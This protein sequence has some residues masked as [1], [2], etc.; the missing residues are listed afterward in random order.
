MKRHLVILTGILAILLGV[1]ILL[2]F[3]ETIRIQKTQ[4]RP[5]LAGSFDFDALYD[6][7]D[8]A[9]VRR[10]YEAIRGHA[11]RLSGSEGDLE[12]AGVAEQHFRSL[13]MEVIVQR[14]P[15]TVPVTR[16][17]ELLEEGTEEEG[18]VQDVTITPFWPNVIRTCTTPATGI[19]G[20][21][22]DAGTG[23]LPDL[24]GKP[25]AGRIALVEMTPA[26]EWLDVAKLG[27]AAILFKASADAED[28]RKKLLHFP[29]NIPRFLVEGD[30]VDE[31]VGRTVRLNARVDWAV[32]EA[33]SVFGILRPEIE[34]NEALFLIADSDSWSVVPD[35]APGD[36]EAC[37]LAGLLEVATSLSEQRSALARTIV[38]T[39][40]SGRCLGSEGVRRF[41]DVLGN[42]EL[43]EMNYKLL[44]RRLD[45]A[46][47]QKT[48]SEGALEA[49]RESSF[50]ALDAQGA[51]R[52]WNTHGESAKDAFS[53][54]LQGLIDRHVI[55]MQDAQSDAKLAW[56][57]AGRPDAGSLFDAQ[58]KASNRLRRARAAAGADTISLKQVFTD[59]LDAGRCREE[60]E[61]ELQKRAGYAK[62]AFDWQNDSVR[63]ADALASYSRSYYFWFRPTPNGRALS[64]AGDKTLSLELERARDAIVRTWLTWQ[65]SPAADPSTF[66][67]HIANRIR[68][69]IGSIQFGVGET[70]DQGTL[71]FAIAAHA[72]FRFRGRGAARNYQTPLREAIAFDDV[73]AQSQLMAGMAAQ[74]AS[75]YEPMGLA[76]QD[77]APIY[78]W[79]SDYGGEVVSSSGSRSILANRR[80][81]DA[82]VVLKGTGSG[83]TEGRDFF[84][85]RSRDGFFRI[86][87]CLA[88]RASNALFCDAYTI[89]DRTGEIT[90]ARDLGA[91][92]QKYPTYL[93]KDQI[94]REP[95]NRVTIL[96]SQFAPTDIY[97][98]TG[99]EGRRLRPELLDAN[100]RSIPA[101]FA[102]WTYGDEGGTLFVPPGQRFY[103]VLKEEP[104]TRGQPS[105]TRGFL[106]GY[107]PEETPGPGK[108]GFWGP[109]YL[110]G[111]DHRIRFQDFDAAVSVAAA[112]RERLDA[113]VRQGLG[114]AAVLE[115]AGKAD[116]FLDRAADA[117]GAY[118]YTAAYRDLNTSLAISN[119]A[120]PLVRKAVADALAGLLLYLFL[121]VPF[122]LFAE[123]LL[124]GSNDIR[125][126]IAGTFAI[127]IFLFFLIQTLHPVYELI[128]S[129]MIVLVGFVI[130]MLCVLILA[131]LSGKFAER[132][133]ELRL[134]GGGA[135]EA[136]SDVSRAS[137]AGTAFSLGVNSM[138]KR[139]VRTAYTVATL[140]LISFSMVCFTAPHPE[141]VTRKVVAGQADFNGILLRRP[142]NFSPLRIQ[143]GDKAQIIM[144]TGSSWQKSVPPKG[145]GISYT[146][147]E[148]AIR[149][150]TVHT[151]MHLDA[152]EPKLTGV[153]ETLLP[154]GRWFESNE[155]ESM[156]ISEQMASTLGIDPGELND[157]DIFVQ[158]GGFD[159]KLI[160]VFSSSAM[161]QLEDV[162]GEPLLPPAWSPVKAGGRQRSME[163]TQRLAGPAGGKVSSLYR[164]P[165]ADTAILPFHPTRVSIGDD[166]ATSAVIAF[167]ELPYGEMSEMIDTLMDR[168][169]VFFT[170][171]LDGVSFFG[172]KLRSVGMDKLIDLGVPLLIASF[173]VFTTMLGSVYERQ[174][175]ISVYSAVGLSPR[176]VF[177]LFLAESLVYGVI[178]VVGGYMLGLTLQGVSHRFG[179]FLGL[180][181]DYSSRS[182][183]YVCLTIM[184][185]VIASTFLP[186]R[187]A[188][189]IASPSE[190]VSWRMP[191]EVKEGQLDFQ[192]PF[193]Y[194][195][196]DILAMVP[197]LTGWFDERGED[198]SG[199]FSA[200]PPAVDIL[201]PNDLPVF[202]VESTAWLRPYD[203]GVSQRVRI[204]LRPSEDPR[205]YIVGIAIHQLTGDLNSWR[206]T[207]TR[208]VKILRRHLLSWRA[209]SQRGKDRLYEQGRGMLGVGNE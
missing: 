133:R 106:L 44:T 31:L 124:V 137:A 184:A 76:G 147:A 181:I 113:Q 182:A 54:A 88:G 51:A 139:P 79:F 77:R 191:V 89:D 70:V 172:G 99:T 162:D 176:H 175:E 154:G 23:V 58:L 189:K 68:V 86:P 11:T 180:A 36:F 146:P 109:G 204:E 187:R 104:L 103:A 55:V 97:R 53:D 16:V 37:S 115:F 127:F 80:V 12:A 6:S 171:A 203:L 21:V 94:Y 117:I 108:D 118:E 71:P 130:F 42:R 126:R 209:L 81:A 19:V 199:E 4:P 195:G 2:R 61:E 32:R 48:A 179:D 46:A 45:E 98:L 64:F 60:L 3:Q 151:L 18:P 52:L 96:L 140:V 152:E 73:A 85:Q 47:E 15:V 159:R 100:F 69:R 173:I 200:S 129:G 65:G 20:E 25:I 208:F 87:A 43:F 185:A 119:R 59:V 205:I 141:L 111:R 5:E 132:I 165:G 13:G 72:E 188:A 169:P 170:F 116:R 183:I 62:E 120:Y 84:V 123:R 202:A 112:N 198:S 67:D 193:T 122:S 142:G 107:E 190:R 38:F 134:R 105:F 128:T 24:D 136:D 148:G 40:L 155:E 30:G 177:Y 150:T 167:D 28:Y 138:R 125:A 186:A 33:R 90:G 63:L 66:S 49:Y 157:R 41:L 50:W 26:M 39:T 9:G 163:K 75:G 161:D 83:G 164:A 206:R 22:V 194:L 8:G 110:A 160:G 158:F 56:V 91:A 178:G 29:A 197:F 74:V 7:I 196:R 35:L 156:I 57:E 114:D 201:W 17:C 93:G 149:A 14:F 34:S 143:F 92:G 27:A 166:D 131:F 82:M 135:A 207:N 153:D 101:E 121:L 95:E 78:S 174:K 144:R 168:M 102:M 192:L 10:G 1:A 145:P